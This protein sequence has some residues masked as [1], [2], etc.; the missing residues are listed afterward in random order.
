MINEII[1]LLSIIFI[2]FSSIIALYF[3]AT[4]LTALVCLQVVLMNLFVTKQMMLC[5]LNATTAD[6]LGIGA[7]L[8]INL[9]R[10][11]YGA[12]IARKTVYLSF[13]I[14]LFYT[15]ITWLQLAYVPSTCDVQHVHFVAI[16]GQM[17]RI[18]AAS[19]FTYMLIESIEYYLYDYFKRKFDGH[20]FIVRNYGVVLVTQLLDTILFTILG[21]YGIID[22]VSEVITVSYAIKAV[23]IICMT[24]L[25]VMCKKAL[26]WFGYAKI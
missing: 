6:A 22:N 4:A 2:A 16:L 20:Y 13:G 7:V 25:L 12:A 17:P 24:P 18:L 14:V 3:S 15:I 8:G 10:E 19:L 9:L 1:F 21:L 23:T 11:Y 26:E 5:G